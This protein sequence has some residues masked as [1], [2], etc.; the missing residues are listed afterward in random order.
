M[1]DFEVVCRGLYRALCIR[2]KNMQQSLQR[3]PKTPSQYLRTIE[4]ETWKPSDSGPG[5]SRHPRGFLWFQHGA[6]LRKGLCKALPRPLLGVTVVTGVSLPAVWG[7]GA[8]QAWEVW[9]GSLM[10]FSFCCSV[11]PTSEGWTGSL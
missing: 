4:G 7:G 8:R 11:H 5:T 1:E 6:G 9:A 10:E 2:E 3:F